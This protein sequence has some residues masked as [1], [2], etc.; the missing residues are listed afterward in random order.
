MGD[1]GS[2]E[3]ILVKDM[4]W[5]SNNDFHTIDIHGKETIYKNAQYIGFSQKHDDHVIKVEEVIKMD[6]ARV[7]WDE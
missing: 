6:V 3:T 4:W 5:D 1:S 2:K 7:L